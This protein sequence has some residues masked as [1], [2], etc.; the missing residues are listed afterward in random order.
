MLNLFAIKYTSE[1]NDKE[2]IP[3]EE[4]DSKESWI[5]VIKYQYT[6]FFG[7]AFYEHTGIFTDI[8]SATVGPL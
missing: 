4:A 1:K 2:E 8:S 7:N 3:A 5:Y 6:D